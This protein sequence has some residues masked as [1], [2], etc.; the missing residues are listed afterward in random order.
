M[1]AH[2]AD[3]GR[4]QEPPHPRPRR[5]PTSPP[6]EPSP[7]FKAFCG[8]VGRLMGRITADCADGHCDYEAVAAWFSRWFAGLGISIRFAFRKPNTYV[9]VPH[10]TIFCTRADGPRSAFYVY[11]LTGE[12]FVLLLQRLRSQVKT[13][14]PEECASDEL[15]QQMGDAIQIFLNEERPG[16]P[17]VFERFMEAFGAKE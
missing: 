6:A 3:N 9:S 12:Q 2:Q 7:A 14:G 17:G 1:D 11:Q 5:N 8:Q 4:P 15:C 13:I 16:E 10:Y